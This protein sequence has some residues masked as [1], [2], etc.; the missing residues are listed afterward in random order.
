MFFKEK[1]M[2]IDDCPENT[3]IDALKECKLAKKCE[4]RIAWRLGYI[5]DY[6]QKTN[7]T[8][9][10]AKLEDFVAKYVVFDTISSSV[11]RQSPKGYVYV[12]TFKYIVTQFNVP[13]RYCGQIVNEYN[14]IK[15]RERI[16][17]KK[18]KENLKEK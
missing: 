10:Q 9:I 6:A 1:K 12:K 7:N 13:D 15:A 2:F 3:P 17:A 18:L 5:C 4:T 11:K 16:A 8:A 14:K